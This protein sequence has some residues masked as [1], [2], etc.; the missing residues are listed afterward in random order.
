MRNLQFVQFCKK[1]LIEQSEILIQQSHNFT[2]LFEITLNLQYDIDIGNP[3]YILG[4][5]MSLD[6][7]LL[8]YCVI[9]QVVL[10]SNSG[11]TDIILHQ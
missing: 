1:T 9:V 3:I 8:H 6:T 2:A 5:S 7:S 10:Y 4:S 11:N